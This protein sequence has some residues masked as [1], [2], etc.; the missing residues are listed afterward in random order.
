MST[1]NEALPVARVYAE[2]AWNLAGKTDSAEEFVEEYD[3]FIRDLVDKNAS[4]DRFLSIPT[5]S[6]DQRQ[7]VLERT[8]RGKMS[9]LLLNFLLTLNRHDRLGLV[10]ACQD[11]LHELLDGKKGAVTVQVRSAVPLSQD[12]QDAVEAVV[13]EKFNVVPRLSLA[14]DPD[15]LGGLWIRVGD[16][17]LDRTLRTNLRKLRDL[18]ETRSTY[19]IQSGRSYFDS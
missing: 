4:F 5:I 16:T 15:L 2:A 6:R 8:L 19:E 17:I 10:R 12:L 13:R 11:A 9:D 3:S 14:V 18:I 7:G 1:E